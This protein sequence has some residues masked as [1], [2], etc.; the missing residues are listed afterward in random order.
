MD[1]LNTNEWNE[2]KESVQK[3]GFSTRRL[4]DG[5][6]D[7]KQSDDIYMLDIV[8]NFFKGLSDSS[9]LE[10]WTYSGIMDASRWYVEDNIKPQLKDEYGNDD[11]HDE[12]LEM[13]ESAFE[14]AAMFHRLVAFKVESKYR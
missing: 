6:R 7:L 14:Y 5:R 1:M 10:T 9:Q 13:W 2:F 8:E 12:T 4:D 3:A 11:W